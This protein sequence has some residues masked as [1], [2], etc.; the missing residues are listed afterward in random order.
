MYVVKIKQM[1]Q[2]RVIPSKTCGYKKQTLSLSIGQQ[3]KCII[4]AINLEYNLFDT[5][6]ENLKDVDARGVQFLI[7]AVF[8]ERHRY[9]TEVL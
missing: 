2:D 8:G 3:C 7:L 6:R 5:H 4:C 1:S 9:V